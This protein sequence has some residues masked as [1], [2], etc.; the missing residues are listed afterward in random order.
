MI[1][2]SNTRLSNAI[3]LLELRS[4]SSQEKV[5]DELLGLIDDIRYIAEKVYGNWVAIN[6]HGSIPRGDFVFGESDADFSIITQDALP[7]GHFELRRSLLEEIVPKWGNFGVAKLDVVA[8]P[9]EEIHESFRRIILFFCYSDG[10]NIDGSEE[11]DLSFVVPQTV[12]ELTQLLN[13]N[14]ALWIEVV[15]EKGSKDEPFVHQLRKRTIRAVYAYAMLQGAPY[16]RG[17]RTYGPNIEMYARRYSKLYT[18]LVNNS[19][20]F[21][22]LVDSSEIVRRDLENAGIKFEVEWQ[23]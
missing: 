21:A 2:K 4:T 6:W 15:K 7:E 1:K 14:F 18:D 5:P 13:K 23:K 9:I 8:V 3:N 11:L 22:G 16:L 17:W 12:Q 10:F 19:V 20:S